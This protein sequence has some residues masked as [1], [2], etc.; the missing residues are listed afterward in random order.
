MSHRK[1]EAV[2][3]PLSLPQVE[4]HRDD[5]RAAAHGRPLVLGD[6]QHHGGVRRLSGRAAD[7]RMTL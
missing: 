5:S 7:V 1:S 6:R 4:L 2:T 3:P